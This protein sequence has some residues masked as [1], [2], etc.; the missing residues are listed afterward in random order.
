MGLCYY[1]IG[2]NIGGK[3]V[4]ELAK[5]NYSS[6]SK[7][8]TLGYLQGQ[9]IFTVFEKKILYTYIDFGIQMRI[10]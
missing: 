2:C 4:K 9:P 3:G 8:V 7:K 10:I 5:V 1:Y 6:S